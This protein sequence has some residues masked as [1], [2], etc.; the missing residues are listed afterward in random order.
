MTEDIGRGYAT[1][2][3]P[4]KEADAAFAPTSIGLAPKVTGRLARKYASFTLLVDS[5]WQKRIRIASAQTQG[6]HDEERPV[7][8][9]ESSDDQDHLW[10]SAGTPAGRRG[11]RPDMLSSTVVNAAM[12]YARP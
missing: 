1:W 2:R 3:R 5:G 10:P 6:K 4:P 7:D 8:D 11:T 12:F 9:R